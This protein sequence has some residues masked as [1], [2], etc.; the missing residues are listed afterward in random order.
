[1]NETAE[2]AGGE[3]AREGYRAALEMITYEGRQIWTV[4]RAML[5]ANAFLVALVGGITKVYP[6][7]T[8]LIN[9]LP[10]L[11]IALCL[12]WLLITVRQFG[13]Y[14]YWFAWAR[15]LEAAGFG[16]GSRMVRDGRRF[17]DGEGVD[18]DGGRERLNWLARLF[19][20]QWLIYG[21]IL[22]FVAI[23]LALFFGVKRS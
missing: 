19:R 14:R 18:V 6:E 4:F 3:V 13:F 2:R 23:Y 8:L 16:G 22:L 20:I 7:L 21:F 1:M 17:S 15:H 11:G 5:A 12:A 10:W 9:G